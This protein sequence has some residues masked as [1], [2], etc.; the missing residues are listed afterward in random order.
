MPG[1]VFL[2]VCRSVA[3]P[4][5]LSPSCTLWQVFAFKALFL[6][7]IHVKVFKE[8]LVSHNSVSALDILSASFSTLEPT[9]NDRCRHTKTISEISANFSLGWVKVASCNIMNAHLGC[10]WGHVEP[11]SSP[12]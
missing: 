8:M 4:T 6:V 10:L 7:H 9:I 3:I 5:R 11:K 2:E 12:M 1:R